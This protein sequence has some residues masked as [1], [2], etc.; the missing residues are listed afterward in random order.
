[1]SLFHFLHFI[2]S[3]WKLTF[4]CNET[5]WPNKWVNAASRNTQYFTIYASHN[6]SEKRWEK[7]W[8]LGVWASCMAPRECPLLPP[9]CL[10]C[11]SQGHRYRPDKFDHQLS[12]FFL[13][14]NFYS[15]LH[16]AAKSLSALLLFPSSSFPPSSITSPPFPKSCALLLSAPFLSPLLLQCNPRPCLIDRVMMKV[17]GGG[18]VV[19]CFL[20]LWW[21]RSSS[22]SKLKSCL[23]IPSL[24]RSFLC[25]LSSC[26]L[27]PCIPLLFLNLTFSSFSFCMK[28]SFAKIASLSETLRY[29]WK[30][31]SHLDSGKHL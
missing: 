17:A 22:L 13:S 7:G 26:F 25:Y 16:Q 18:M 6:C 19:P 4:A 3:L 30:L 1:M 2:S 9:N 23:S 8:N 24:S 12:L 31:L 27:F 14:E 15:G 20:L 5:T 21:R 10:N 28:P 11:S 29:G